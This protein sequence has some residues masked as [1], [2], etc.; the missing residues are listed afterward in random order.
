M[1][2]LLLSGFAFG[3]RLPDNNEEIQ[4]KTVEGLEGKCVKITDCKTHTKH[5]MKQLNKETTKLF[6]YVY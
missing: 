6:R 4:C 2:V 1:L 3:F 5:L